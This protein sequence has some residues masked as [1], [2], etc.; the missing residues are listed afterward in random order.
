MRKSLC[1]P[2][3]LACAPVAFT[4]TANEEKTILNSSSNLR[5]FGLKP[6]APP[7]PPYSTELWQT[8]SLASAPTDKLR[9]RLSF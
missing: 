1:I 9:A 4:Q 8:I 3:V 2:L 5:P 6:N 7:I